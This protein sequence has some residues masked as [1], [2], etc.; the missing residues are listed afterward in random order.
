MK[1]IILASKSP[2]RKEIFAKLNLPFKVVESNFE[3]DMTLKMNPRELAKFLS[4]EKAKEVAERFR[5]HIVI[6]ADTFVVLSG[7][8]L[9]KPRT[10]DI[11]K[12][13]LK[14]TSGKEVEVISGVTII[15]SKTGR[16][17]SKEVVSKIKFREIS[18]KE[19]ANYVATGI[20]L[21]KAG[22][23]AVQEIGAI[24]IERI[25]GDYFNNMGL[26]LFEIA[27]ILKEFEIYPL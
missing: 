16:S 21:D 12:K 26:P 5:N 8:L 15:D 10:P 1:K 14:K 20:P 24:F 6:G 2:R 18:N 9:G 25:E 27:Q 22:A 13:M 7:E 3:E 4:R 11:A 23:I 19:I 17:I